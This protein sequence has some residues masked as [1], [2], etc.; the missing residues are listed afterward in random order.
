LEGKIVGLFLITLIGGLA[1]GFGLSYIN[2]QAQVL[3]LQ[4]TTK[5]LQN[6]VTSLNSTLQGLLN[7]SGAGTHNQV[8]V[9]GNISERL[10]SKIDFYS[11]IPSSQIQ[12]SSLIT[13][14]KYSV[15]LVGGQSYSVFVY[16]LEV[17]SIIPTNS[18]YS[19]YVPLG[20]TTFTANF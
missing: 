17:G 14:G 9:S 6:Q 8:Q 15:V 10:P 20:I 16:W 18:T 12:T 11:N 7:V 19:L 13:D 4:N 2:Y 3:N 1:G 5:N